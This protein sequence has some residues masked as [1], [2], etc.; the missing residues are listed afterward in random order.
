MVTD[1]YAGVG[2][3]TTPANVCRFFT[4]LAGRL[5]AD[6]FGLQSG[7]AEGSDRAF[8]NGVVDPT[9]ARIF[10][11][12][13]TFGRGLPTYRVLEG[14]VLDRCLLLAS[15]VHPAWGACKSGARLLH[16]RN[17]AQIWGEDLV[18]PVKFVLCWAEANGDEI[19]GGTRTA[20]VLARAASIPV[21]NFAVAGTRARFDAFRTTLRA[22]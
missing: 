4:H 1:W 7:G 16:S 10:V 6:G 17:V 21:F 9:N 22:A 2:S 12:W 13:P 20:V 5:E 15:V 14:P 8:E 19:L 11:P 3:R 18:S